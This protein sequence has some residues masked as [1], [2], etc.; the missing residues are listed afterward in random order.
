V[1]WFGTVAMNKNSLRAAFD[2]L[3]DDYLRHQLEEAGEDTLQAC[4]NEGLEVESYTEVLD[5]PWLAPSFEPGVTHFGPFGLRVPPIT[6][7][8]VRTSRLVLRSGD[9]KITIESGSR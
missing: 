3:S 2:K 4:I 9:C 1:N 6:E 8:K 5:L 7:A